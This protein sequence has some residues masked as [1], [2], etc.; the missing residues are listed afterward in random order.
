LISS[1]FLCAAF[2]KLF[3]AELIATCEWQP[4]QLSATCEWHNQQN[5]H[6][7][8]HGENHFQKQADFCLSD[9]KAAHKHVDEIDA[10]SQC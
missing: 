10:R 7:K 8:K 9:E 4:A 6:T 5:F 1:T 3:C 2:L